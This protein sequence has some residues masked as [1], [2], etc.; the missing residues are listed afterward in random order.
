[1]T[2]ANKGQA[3]PQRFCVMLRLKEE[4]IEAMDE[5]LTQAGHTDRSRFLRET[6]LARV[7]GVEV[8]LP[9]GKSALKKVADAVGVWRA[10]GP[11]FNPVQKSKAPQ[12]AAVPPS[13]EYPASS[14]P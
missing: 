4:E 1:M 11:E 5:A 10:L 8:S 6:V 9:K 7:A 14:Q 2:K 12:P 3:N 13:A